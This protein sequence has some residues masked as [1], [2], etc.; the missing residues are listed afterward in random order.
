V[1]GAADRGAD[2]GAPRARPRGADGAVDGNLQVLHIRRGP[3]VQ[4]HQI[5]RMLM[6]LPV[7]MGADRLTQ[8]GDVGGVVD[9]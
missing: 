4:H 9:P 1:N 8:D 7:F 6:H 5:N 3:V 2:A